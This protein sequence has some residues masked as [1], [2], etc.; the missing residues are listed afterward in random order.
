MKVTQA[1][2]YAEENSC[3]EYLGRVI[4]QSRRGK[5]SSAY[6]PRP[7]RS[8]DRLGMCNSPCEGEDRTMEFISMES[9][10]QL[11]RASAERALRS[12]YHFGGIK[13]LASALG[14]TASQVYTLVAKKPDFIEFI[15][16]YALTC[17]LLRDH[18]ESM[19]E[20]GLGRTTREPD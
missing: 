1:V 5:V 6:M 2:M 8:V 19:L 11:E 17:T 9:N 18:V 13:A 7:R 10:A 3:P 12:W 16:V 14:V 4:G 15:P 20:S